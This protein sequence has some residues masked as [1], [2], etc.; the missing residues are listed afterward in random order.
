MSLEIGCQPP[1]VGC[2]CNCGYAFR[3][4]YG[5]RFYVRPYIEYTVEILA[6]AKFLGCASRIWS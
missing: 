5:F 1:I 6:G 3:S 2:V 4:S